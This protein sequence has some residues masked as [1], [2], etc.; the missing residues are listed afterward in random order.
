M[1]FS[2]FNL[3]QLSDRKILVSK[4]YTI[5][6]L[7]NLEKTITKKTPHRFFTDAA[8][9]FIQSNVYLNRP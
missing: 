3:R 1:D 2:C 7:E 6:L 9:I 4:N 5:W 8:L